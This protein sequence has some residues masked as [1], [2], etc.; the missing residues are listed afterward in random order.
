MYNAI[1]LELK[2]IREHP[3][4]DRLNVVS[5]FGNQVIIG[6]DSCKEGDTVI[7]F[8]S[9]GILSE[10]FCKK[11][12]LHRHSNLNDDVNVIGYIEDNRRI[13]AIRLR[14]EESDGMLMP[15]KCLTYTGYNLEKLEPGLQ[16]TELKGIKFCEKYIPRIKNSGE[17]NQNRTRRKPTKHYELFK[18]HID[19]KQL[20]YNIDQIKKGDLVTLTSKIH[21]TSQRS[22]YTLVTHVLPK[23]KELINSGIKIFK[24]KKEWKSIYG[25]RRTIRDTDEQKKVSFY[26]TEN[27]RESHHKLFDG[28]LAKGET[29]YYEVAGYTDVDRPIMGT[30]DTKKLNDKAFVKQYGETMSFTYGCVNGQSKIYVYRM[31][32][33]NE[34]GFTVDYSWNTIKNRCIEMGIEYVPEVMSSFIFDGN[35]DKLL[36]LVNDNI[37]G[38]STLDARHIKEGVVVRAENNSNF[39]VWKHKGWTFKVL[40][41]II[42]DAGV[43]DIEEQEEIIKI[44][45]DKNN[46]Q[47]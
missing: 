32:L 46:E 29:V 34:D 36:Q 12:N 40:E 39:N 11:N 16:L 14:G 8:P 35:H 23:W 43:A 31:T 21:G 5:V 37:E 4:A 44:E 10:D 6:K 27:F 25:T 30:V 13:R 15:I 45:R 24:S 28:R 9:D 19:T 41:G 47:K 18:E 7:Y 1:I 17:K 2:N 20:A 33:T 22:S 26:D 3:N 42:K 38:P